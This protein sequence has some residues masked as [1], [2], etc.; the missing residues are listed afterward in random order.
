[1][2]PSDQQMENTGQ[3][4]R[5]LLSRKITDPEIWYGNRVVNP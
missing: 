4:N 1:L 2:G 5:P 3:D